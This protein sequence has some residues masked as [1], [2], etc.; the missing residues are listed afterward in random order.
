[1]SYDGAGHDVVLFGGSTQSCGTLTCS[2]TYLN[3]TWAFLGNT[4]VQWSPDNIPSPRANAMMAYDSATNSVVLFGGT[5][6]NGDVNDTWSW[7]GATWTQL[8]PATSPSARDTGY[9]AYSAVMGQVVLFGGSGN[10]DTW[11]WNGTTWTLQAHGGNDPTSSG[12]AMAYD[13]ATQNVVYQM[14]SNSYPTYNWT[15]VCCNQPP[16]QAA[17]SDQGY[18]GQPNPTGSA[19][20]YD[21]STQK[22]IMF[23]GD[24][25]GLFG[26][27]VNN[28]T[29]SYNGF[30]WTQLSPATSPSARYGHGF[31]SD[32]DLG[33]AVLFGGTDASGNILA[34]TWTWNDPPAAAISESYDFKYPQEADGTPGLVTAPEAN[35]MANIVRSSKL[36]AWAQT[37]Y[38]A[39]YA[40]NH[41]A[42]DSIFYFA[43]HSAEYDKVVNGRALYQNWS[44]FHYS[45][46]LGSY[47]G[48]SSSWYNPSAREYYPQSMQRSNSLAVLAACNTSTPDI[49]NVSLIQGFTKAGASAALGFG[50]NIKNQPYGS[51]WNTSFWTYFKSGYTLTTCADKAWQYVASQNGG[52]TGG[53]DQVSFSG[54]RSLTDQF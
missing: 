41:L 54:N 52:K 6:A 36:D 35:D 7:D 30:T 16:T 13:P 5:T 44:L 26:T 2:T 46:G 25:A 8:S 15:P 12:G 17:W 11:T 3:D 28:A 4:W 49:Y 42:Q 21:P 19:M 14:A 29:W 40:V 47:I 22:N 1:M 37:N 33:G 18:A 45:R 23:G 39:S 43:G 38:S 31:V 50:C 34:D 51:Q 53:W 10:T 20:A 32:P 27:T 9:M 48:P 24:T